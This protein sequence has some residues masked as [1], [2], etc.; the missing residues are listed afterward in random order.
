MNNLDR[1]TAEL[2][3][4]AEEHAHE[5]GMDPER[6]LEVVLE[7]VVAEDDHGISRTNINQQFRTIVVNAADEGA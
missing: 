6:F 4:E 2:S 5:L 1:I 7:L 3:A